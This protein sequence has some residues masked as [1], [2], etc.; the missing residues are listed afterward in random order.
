M[1]YLDHPKKLTISPSQVCQ[2]AA[3]CCD[4]PQDGYQ[5]SP[6]ITHSLGQ[7]SPFFS[8]PS[9]IDSRVPQGCQVTFAQILSRHGARDPTASKTVQYDALIRSVHANTS[10]YGPGYEFIQSYNYTLGADQLT[11]FGQQEL[12]SSGIKF[13]QRYQALASKS[14]PFIRSSAQERVVES[15]RRWTQGFH[16]SLL[17][18]SSATAPEDFPYEIVLISED[19]GMN[20]TLSHSLCT[21]FESGV[22]AN[23]GS[24]AKDEW[25]GVF[26]PAIREKI[27]RNL[28]GVELSSDD[29]INFLDM[30]PFNTVVHGALSPFCKLFTA[31]E[32]QQY[33]YY[34][35]MDKWYGHGPGN[36]LG[37]TQGVGW[38]NELL[39]RLTGTAVIDRTSTN[40][41]L[42]ASSI[43]FPLN[44]TLYADFSHDNDMV[45]ILAALGVYNT[46]TP[47]SNST[48]QSA[49]D[50]GGFSASWVVSFASRI[51]VEKLGCDGSE[52]EMVRILVNDRVVPLQGC[53][54]DALGR[55]TLTKFVES[56][57]FARNG[58]LWDLCFE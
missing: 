34:G 27:M 38:V 4:T 57:S 37:S 36:P 56:Q 32:W 13:Y 24:A 53:D 52:E 55:C 42:D 45:G 47:L 22:F 43:T 35:T 14:L 3:S 28:P 12:I 46:T 30:C 41:T 54:A 2:A 15:A 20:N 58:G 16:N 50:S 40:Q 29:T 10:S 39:A 5:C 17:A 26:M 18:D 11:R 7:Y 49:A 23:I 51:Y 8:V 1:C 44:R 48:F 9:D 6:S 25:A 31:E 21:A 33:D 19:E